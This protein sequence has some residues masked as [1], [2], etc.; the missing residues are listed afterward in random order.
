MHV[1]LAQ[2]RLMNILL[3][4]YCY[5]M[6]MTFILSLDIDADILLHCITELLQLRFAHCLCCRVTRFE[7]ISLPSQAEQVT[8]VYDWSVSSVWLIISFI[9]K[10]KIAKKILAYGHTEKAIITKL[11]CKIITRIRL[12]I[13]KFE[14]IAIIICRALLLNK[15]LLTSWIACI[16][17]DEI[18]LLRYCSRKGWINTVH[19]H[20]EP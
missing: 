19:I 12:F 7:I 16:M 14:I 2:W 13:F 4:L 15:E 5:T 6:D 8:F 18:R 11:K 3:L 1:M 9:I 17:Y 10:W 20:S